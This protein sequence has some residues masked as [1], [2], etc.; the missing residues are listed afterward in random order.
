MLVL[1]ISAASVLLNLCL[2]KVVEFFYGSM[3][4]LSTVDSDD[5]KQN[6]MQ[7][8]VFLE[9]CTHSLDGS[10]EGPSCWFRLSPTWS[11]MVGK[12]LEGGTYTNPDVTSLM[13]TTRR[14]HIDHKSL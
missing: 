14:S 1:I 3:A 2:A 9:V 12:S 7:Q 8:P 10:F 11:S 4:S 6:N 5:K 13:A